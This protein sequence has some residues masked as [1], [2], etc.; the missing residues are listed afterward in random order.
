[1]KF[2]VGDLI[3]NKCTKQDLAVIAEVTRQGELKIK[4]FDN[5]K[6]TGPYPHTAVESVMELALPEEVLQSPLYKAMNE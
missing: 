6:T 4:W 3:W 2:K 1:M 5:G